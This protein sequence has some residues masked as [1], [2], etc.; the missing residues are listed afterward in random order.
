MCLLMKVAVGASNGQ[1]KLN[2]GKQ[3][4]RENEL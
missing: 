2:L 4:V 1:R 3:N